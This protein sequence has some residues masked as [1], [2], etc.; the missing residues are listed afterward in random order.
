MQLFAHMPHNCYLKTRKNKKKPINSNILIFSKHECLNTLFTCMG[1]QVLLKPAKNV[2]DFLR[3]MQMNMEVV[4]AD[5]NFNVFI[6]IYLLNQRELFTLFN[7]K[8]YWS[9]CLKISTSLF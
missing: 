4:G 1:L 2:R 8:K 6:K 7:V 3:I 9:E 5:K